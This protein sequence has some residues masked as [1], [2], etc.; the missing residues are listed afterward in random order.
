M[1]PAG[2][3]KGAAWSEML[4]GKERVLYPMRR[5]GERGE[6]RFERVSWDEALAEISDATAGCDREVGR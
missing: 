4:Y 2:C 1:N 3:Q 5:T 6:G